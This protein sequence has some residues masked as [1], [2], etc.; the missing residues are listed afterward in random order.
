M[1]YT[2]RF[3][4]DTTD[5]NC[6][7]MFDSNVNILNMSIR[8]VSLKTNLRLNRDNIYPLEVENKND[9]LILKGTTV[10]SNVV[11]SKDSGDPRSDF[12]PAYIT[13]M[14]FTDVSNDKLNEIINFIEEYKQKRDTGVNLYRLSDRRH[15]DRI[16][17]NNS[18]RAVLNFSVNCKI[19]ELGISGMLIRSSHELEN[20]SQVFTMI[21]L[22]ENETLKIMGRI[23]SCCF[24]GGRETEQVFD[25]G[26]EFADVSEEDRERLKKFIRSTIVSNSV[27][28][29]KL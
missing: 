24:M 9:N 3:R 25:V 17:I 21:T 29:L 28:K 5:I 27:K 20:E 7:I 10:W 13:G 23:V 15:N 12:I 6:Q 18:K 19:Q 22:S 14:K 4:I 26:V 8:G 16:H 1:E 2:Q 11:L